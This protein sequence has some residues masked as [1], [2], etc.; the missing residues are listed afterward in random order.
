MA[1]EDLK[2]VINNISFNL[3]E[4]YGFTTDHYKSRLNDMIR[5]MEAENKF[6]SLCSYTYMDVFRPIARKIASSDIRPFTESY[7]DLLSDATKEIATGKDPAE[8]INEYEVKLESWC[9]S[10]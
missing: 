6:A 5:I 1:L 7:I 8:L 9:N 10:I 2:Q 3:V 4:I